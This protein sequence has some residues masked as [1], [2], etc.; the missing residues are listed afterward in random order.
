MRYLLDTNICIYI[1]KRSPP[2]VFARF[3]RLR[4][5]EVGISVITFCELQF[6]IARS[7]N[8]DQNQAALNEFLAPL[9]VLDFPSDAAPV[10]GE[11]RAHLTRGGT[12]IG[13]YDLLIATHA[14][15]LGVV[16]VT[17]NAREF[18]RVPNLSTENWIGQET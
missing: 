1:I 2:E 16:L 9:E 17:N 14:L 13:N 3:G 10:F 11:L 5:G 18:S 15:H 12:P 7:A 8:R 6:G 4:V